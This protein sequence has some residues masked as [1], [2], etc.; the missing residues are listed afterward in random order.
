M[1]VSFEMSERE[2]GEGK[3]NFFY[4]FLILV[5]SGK[6]NLPFFV[7]NPPDL[8]TCLMGIKKSNETRNEM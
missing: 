3:E 1:S 7:L 8:V 2:K 4:L 6:E 5:A